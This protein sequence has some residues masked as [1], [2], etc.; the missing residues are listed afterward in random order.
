VLLSYSA[1]NGFRDCVKCEELEIQLQQVH[2]ELSSVQLIIKLLNKERVQGTTV[3]APN[4]E[5]E[6]KR[7]MYGN[8][9]V[10]TQI[11]TK[12]RSEG[13]VKLRKKE[14]T[15]SKEQAVVTTNCYTALETDSHL[16]HNEDEMES[17]YEKTICTRNKSQEGKM[18]HTTQNYSV[19]SASQKKLDMK[20]KAEHNLQNHSQTHQPSNMNNEET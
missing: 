9:E 16:L 7:E 8:W 3:T 4:H 15:N 2:E 20:N 6:T 13:N 12:K 14:L 1:S 17:T 19:T 5:T 11:S 18:K 10:I